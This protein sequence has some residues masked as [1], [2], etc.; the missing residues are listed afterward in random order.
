MAGM[1]RR[2]IRALLSLLSLAL[3]GFARAAGSTAPGLYLRWEQCYTDGGAANRVF[4]CD[5]NAGTSTLVVS[6]EVAQAVSLVSGLEVNVDIATPEAALPAWWQFK[7]VGTCRRTSLSMLAQA[8]ANSVNCVDWSA[9]QAAGGIGSYGVAANIPTIDRY[10]LKLALAVLP[11]AITTLSPGQEYVACL[12]R[13]DHL[14]TV[15]SSACAGCSAPACIKAQ[16]L[17]IVTNT[18]GGA[19]D[20][21]LSLPA[22]GPGSDRVSWQDGAFAG[23]TYQ[24]TLNNGCYTD[25]SCT[26]VTPTRASTWGA[27]KALYR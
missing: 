7:N 14:N 18:P 21:S 2:S 4:A 25:Y 13:F 17:K 5:T 16:W 3:P 27:V 10:R 22:D 19:G 20:V 24:C 26:S 12:L 1:I 11:S 23:L 6:F 9:G 8:P 15:G